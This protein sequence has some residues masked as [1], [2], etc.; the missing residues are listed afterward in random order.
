MYTNESKLKALLQHPLFCEITG[1]VIGIIGTLIVTYMTGNLKFYEYVSI[2]SLNTLIEE[3]LVTPG[4]VDGSILELENSN[5]QFEMLQVSF[6]NCLSTVKN[7]LINLGYSDERVSSM[8]QHDMFESLP[9]IALEIHTNMES[10]SSQNKQLQSEIATLKETVE[11][12]EKRPTADVT[13]ANLIIDG[14]LLNNGGSINN[15]V[16]TVD[17]N[18]YFSQTLLNTFIFQEKIQYNTSEN[19]VIL[20]N[21]KP[22]KVKLSWDIMAS[23]NHGAE[24]YILGEGNTFTMAKNT[25]NEGIVLSDE[26]Y[27]YLHLNSEYSKMSFTYGHVDDTNQ[28]NLELTILALDANGETY[29]TTLKTIT[30]SGEME[31][32]S[33]EIPLG[34]ASAIKFI[35]SNGDSRARYGLT[36]IYLYS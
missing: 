22:E 8:Q 27:L 30:L 26:D 20:G 18:S 2:N 12:L 5:Q 24:S 19:A 6:S 11:E 7:S 25:Y 15:A 36:D 34:Y 35:V 33:I 3:Y 21:Q 13:S 10:Y 29:T 23:D 4:Y 9:K 14:E 31:P 1:V 16:V 17:G 32:K 28:G